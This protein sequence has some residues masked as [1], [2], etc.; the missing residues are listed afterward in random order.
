[1]GY[2]VVIGPPKLEH[3]LSF[4]WPSYLCAI[5]HP[6][7]VCKGEIDWADLHLLRSQLPVFAAVSVTCICHSDLLV[8]QVTTA[9]VMVWHVLSYAPGRQ[10]VVTACNEMLYRR[11]SQQCD[12][13]HNCESQVTFLQAC[14]CDWTC[15]VTAMDICEQLPLIILVWLH[16]P[17][18]Q[19][20]PI[21][22]SFLGKMADC[23]KGGCA[24][25]NAAGMTMPVHS[26]RKGTLQ[27]QCHIQGQHSPWA[28]VVIW[29][30]SQK[31]TTKVSSL[32]PYV[33]TSTHCSCSRHYQSAR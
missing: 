16:L 10:T 22:W 5:P 31:R 12:C 6:G 21:I 2:S 8:L 28:L 3:W 9:S 18:D 23:W 26:C 30:N 14:C 1:M 17:C 27:Q 11:S 20:L 15:S 33:R 24:G 32:V 29:R 7:V 4:P 25:V 19:M 13:S